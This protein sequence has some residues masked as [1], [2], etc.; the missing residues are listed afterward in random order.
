[1][2]YRCQPVGVTFSASGHLTFWHIACIVAHTPDCGINIMKKRLQIYVILLIL[3]CIVI[4]IIGTLFYSKVPTIV[5]LRGVWGSS[6]SD[7]YAV[8]SKTDLFHFDGNSWKREQ[9]CDPNYFYRDI[10]GSSSNDVYAVAS[11]GICRDS[12]DCW[13][14]TYWYW[15]SLLYG[16]HGTSLTDIYAVGE[17]GTILHNNGSSWERINISTSERLWDVWCITLDSAYVVG[18]NGAILHCNGSACRIMDSGTKSYLYGVWGTSDDDVYAV[19]SE[20]VLHYDGSGWDYSMISKERLYGIW[21]SSS[22]DIYAVGGSRI[23]HYD[24]IEWSEM[25]KEKGLG[26][27]GIWGTSSSDIFAVGGSNVLHFDGTKWHYALGPGI[28]RTSFLS[29]LW[30]FLPGIAGMVLLLELG[31]W[32]VRRRRA[33]AGQGDRL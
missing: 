21:G 2:F 9:K 16:I 18:E 13:E 29:F 4:A 8:G 33:G 24:G 20:G 6:S 31:L 3:L 32:W 27:D 1:M 23:W 12:G 26:L 5:S 30:H 7:V 15:E 19:G 22:S 10:W 17:H 14:T 11:N 28:A 25:I